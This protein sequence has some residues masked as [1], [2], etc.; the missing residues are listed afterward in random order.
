MNREA[1]LARTFAELA[2]TLVDDF[3]V[4]QS[5]I[6]GTLAPDSAMDRAEQEHPPALVPPHGC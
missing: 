6:D 2:D 1:V 5:V 4:G 3:D